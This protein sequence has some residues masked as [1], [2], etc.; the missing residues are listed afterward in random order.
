[1][2]PPIFI[3]MYQKYVFRF[4]KLVSTCTR[5]T[6]FVLSMTKH[7]TRSTFWLLTPA[8]YFE[9]NIECTMSAVFYL[10][11]DRTMSASINLKSHQK[12]TIIFLLIWNRIRNACFYLNVENRIKNAYFYLKMENRIKN[13]CFYLKMENRIKKMEN[14]I[15]NAYSFIIPSFFTTMSS[16]SPSKYTKMRHFL[17]IVTEQYHETSM[18]QFCQSEDDIY[19]WHINMKN[20][21]GMSIWIF[22]MSLN[23]DPSFKS[24]LNFDMTL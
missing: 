18:M 10:M 21:D 1:M 13:A 16:S 2:S 9:N 7:C 15:K 12:H 8:K 11:T 22:T 17:I 6:F 19:E 20:Q 4:L 23:F 3:N 5:S 14:R 24:T